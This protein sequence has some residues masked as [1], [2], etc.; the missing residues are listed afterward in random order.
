MFVIFIFILEMGLYSFIFF[1]VALS[2]IV[3][4]NEEEEDA[5]SPFY[6]Y[7]ATGLCASLEYCRTSYRG[8][9]FRVAERNCLDCYHAEPI[10]ERNIMRADFYEYNE[11]KLSEDSE[12]EM[13]KEML[14]FMILKGTSVADRYQGAV[15][16]DINVPEFQDLKT[17]YSTKF[18]DKSC[19]A[20]LK[21][22]CMRINTL[23]HVKDWCLNVLEWISDDVPDLTGP[24][25]YVLM[26]VGKMLE[27]SIIETSEP[28]ATPVT[29]TEDC[30]ANFMPRGRFDWD[31]MHASLVAAACT[32]TLLTPGWFNDFGN[33]QG[34]LG[35]AVQHS[36]WLAIFTG[37]L[38][39]TLQQRNPE[40]DAEIGTKI[41][42]N[43]DDADNFEL[44][45]GSV[46]ASLCAFISKNKKM[47]F[48]PEIHTRNS[49]GCVEKTVGMAYIRVGDF[50]NQKVKSTCIGGG[51][52]KRGI[53]YYDD[54][55]IY[56]NQYTTVEIT[57]RGVTLF[58]PTIGVS[59][60]EMGETQCTNAVGNGPNENGILGKCGLSGA[61]GICNWFSVW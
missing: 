43:A 14:D 46:Y 3:V 55:V 8:Q 27:V 16:K 45:T 22:G 26:L 7:E 40:T 61:G 44:K 11:E 25:S 23:K 9:C 59:L 39:I 60:R 47:R 31:N 38:R 49:M 17:S 21:N 19:V 32:S 2:N 30:W 34:E 57:Q 58:P 54:N 29:C 52:I 15:F 33:E 6:D 36:L 12:N 13:I 42:C 48:R 53:T 10:N 1:L 24:G 35:F 51:L 18:C 41:L 37:R 20:V 50:L 28:F 4:A 5:T 56:A